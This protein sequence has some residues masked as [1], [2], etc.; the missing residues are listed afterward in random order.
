MQE[1]LHK[2]Q[3][4]ELAD[5]GWMQMKDLLQ[6]HGLE[7]KKKPGIIAFWVYRTGALTACILLAISAFIYF[8]DSK[9]ENK[10]IARIDNHNP[11]SSS[12]K[13][14]IKINSEN[15]KNEKHLSD[16]PIQSKSGIQ[17]N[18]QSNRATKTIIQNIHTSPN[19]IY[20]PAIGQK[21]KIDNHVFTS[22][23]KNIKKEQAS[24]KMNFKNYSKIDFSKNFTQPDLKI[25]ATN[26]EIKLPVEFY[27]GAGFN[28][29]G[30]EKNKSAFSI[31]RINIHPSARIIF[32]LNQK[33]SIQ[34]GLYAFSSIKSKEA[35]TKEKELVNNINANLYYKIN[36][37]NIVKTV[38]FEVPVTVQY[39]LSKNWTAGGGLKISRLNT[40]DVKEVKES[41]DYNENITATSIERYVA[42]GTT[43]TQ[44]LKNKLTIK[45]WEPGLVLETTYKKGPVLFS[46]GFHYGLSPSITIKN[47]NGITNHFKNDYF[48]L[49]VQYRI[50]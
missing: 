8:S 24:I 31:S 12:K 35:M 11:A 37:T 22:Y 29:S 2:N 45:K 7:E 46:A 3:L 4:D 36:T 27:G 48:K 32:P 19:T 17:K 47:P 26:E 25:N 30:K 38:Y 43:G 6:K 5:E 16:N 15:K 39:H 34:T 28:I 1:N 42:M 13:E 14:S 10:N 40:F 9:M 49:G 21:E 50:K 44:A 41:Y 18:D 20:I 33:L 23:V